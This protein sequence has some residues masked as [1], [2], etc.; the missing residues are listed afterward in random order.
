MMKFF[1]IQLNSGDFVRIISLNYAKQLVLNHGLTEDDFA[2]YPG[3]TL[4]DERGYTF[5]LKGHPGAKAMV[6]NTG[7]VIIKL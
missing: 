1:Q 5:Y 7:E 2:V 3:A 6:S 4:R